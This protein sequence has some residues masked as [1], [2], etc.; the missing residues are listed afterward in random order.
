MKKIKILI[1]GCG[2]IG[3]RYFQAIAQSKL[4]T[5]IIIVESN[6]DNHKNV[7]QEW[8]KIKNIEQ[9][10]KIKF[11]KNLNNDI[12]DI[13]LAIIATGS[14]NRL[15]TIKDL[16]KKTTPKYL[17]LEKL[18]VQSSQDLEKLS[19]IITGCKKIW[20]SKPRRAMKW[21]KD[22]KSK[23][24]KFTP[25][26]VYLRGGYWE[27]A[28]CAIH[29]ID[30]INF[31]TGEKVNFMEIS[32]SKSKWFKS[33]RQGFYEFTGT[34]IVYFNKGSKLKLH[35][36]YEGIKEDLLKITMSNNKKWIINEAKGVAISTD[37]KKLFGSLENLSSQYTK[38]IEDIVFTCDC[39][40]PTLD[41]SLPQHHFFLKTM[42]S[43]WN[44]LNNLKDRNVPIT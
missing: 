30:L 21:F 20:V 1:V 36:R 5:D 41:I 4:Y 8:E 2:N 12:S 22:I 35:S 43:N 10:K 13:H 24:F 23:I 31:W 25:I 11:F 33:K 15:E 29:Y 28:S 14:A 44:N 34:L 3:F 7:K 32:G 38:I 16:F 37:R 27:L 18:L 6:I 26:N 39:E 42:L 40:L 17:I 19:E 9:K